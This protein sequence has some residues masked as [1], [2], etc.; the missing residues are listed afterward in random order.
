MTTSSRAVKAKNTKPAAKRTSKAKPQKKQSDTATDGK[1]LHPRNPHNAGYDFTALCAASPLLTP[2]VIEQKGHKTIDFSDAQAVKA[3]NQALLAH[4]YQIYFW[5]IPQGYLCPPIPGRLDN[6]LYLGDLLSVTGRLESAEGVRSLT[7]SVSKKGVPHLQLSPQGENA[8]VPAGKKVRALDVG[9]GA[10]CVFPMLGHVTYGWRFV[11]SDINPV[12]IS[13][14]KLLSRSNPKMRD[15][16]KP[17]LQSNPANIFAGVVTPQDRFDITLC[18]PPFHTS[19]AQATAGSAR[20]VANR[21]KTKSAKGKNNQGDKPSLNFGG[22][23][24]ELWCEGGEVAFIKNMIDESQDVAG[25]VLWFSTLVSKKD[26]LSPLYK[27]L[28]EVEP[29]AVVTIPMQQGN[30]QARLLAWTFF[31]QEE[32]QEWREQFW[33]EALTEE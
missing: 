7:S 25:Q 11:G 23:A 30:K 16:L 19:E 33:G 8:K 3:L 31:P 4:Y 2:F 6:L 12:A 18:N 15:T 26:S 10:N 22:Q 14:A 21:S 24:A 20:K 29:A 13:Q 5:D 32:Q 17:R 27:A 1:G 28:A 9:M